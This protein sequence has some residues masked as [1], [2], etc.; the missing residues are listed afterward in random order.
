M[1]W[2]WVTKK[3]RKAAELDAEY[4]S[5]SSLIDR[6][7]ELP[8]DTSYPEIERTWSTLDDRARAGFKM[9]LSA[10]IL[11][12]QAIRTPAGK[13][14]LEKLVGL[15]NSIDRAAGATTTD[16]APQTKSR[17][18]LIGATRDRIT[19]LVDKAGA[20]PRGEMIA[21]LRRE[22]DASRPQIEAKGAAT[23]NA[24]SAKLNALAARAE[25]MANEPETRAALVA[26]RDAVIAALAAQAAEDRSPLPA[27]AESNPL[28]EARAALDACAGQPSPDVGAL[29]T[30]GRSLRDARYEAGELT[31]DELER[32]T[33]LDAEFA[34]SESIVLERRRAAVQ[35]RVA[36]EFVNAAAGHEAVA[37]PPSHD[38]R[39]ESVMVGAG[40]LGS[41]GVSPSDLLQNMVDA[42][43][44]QERED[45]TLTAARQKSFADLSVSLMDAA[46]ITEVSA[47]TDRCWELADELLTITADRPTEPVSTSELPPSTEDDTE[48]RLAWLEQ[49]EKELEQA[50]EDGSMSPARA[51]TYRAQIAE[52][53]SVMRMSQT[54]DGDKTLYRSR[55]SRLLGRQL[56]SMEHI[57]SQAAG[58]R[59]Q[60]LQRVTGNWQ[61]LLLKERTKWLRRPA[62]AKR[63]MRSAYAHRSAT[64]R[65]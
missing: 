18:Q 54:T 28:A 46:R 9:T 48:K 35:R 6:L 14:R 32:L 30:V 44:R 31:S 45:G 51:A 23:W 2:E 11:K 8:P 34:A 58:S 38:D 56:E 50:V 59:A 37:P 63:L 42:A 4:K 65:R 20:I 13:A 57:A 49:Y 19:A 25:A 36:I 5:H 12:Q 16:A 26:F 10:L 33:A 15:R 3:A 21:A 22:L 7:S 61:T 62:R 17:S 1:A 40:A 41:L 64:H 29:M 47:L 55:L 60:V 43:L 52:A 27:T 53:R 39:V 24:L